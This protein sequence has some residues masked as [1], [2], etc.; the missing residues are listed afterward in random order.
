M[1]VWRKGFVRIGMIRLASFFGAYRED[2]RGDLQ[3][4][5]LPGAVFADEDVEVR[6]QV[7]RCRRKYGQVP[8]CE[9]L[10]GR[11]GP[12][13]DHGRVFVRARGESVESDFEG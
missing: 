13:G 2:G 11:G 8:T 4:M 7:K 1:R 3:K 10:Q 12:R 5:G 9:S 6:T